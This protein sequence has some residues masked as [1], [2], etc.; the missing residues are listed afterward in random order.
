MGIGQR[1]QVQ[2][3]QI[4]SVRGN[5]HEWVETEGQKVGCWAEISNPRGYREYSDGQ[6]Q[7]GTTKVFLI[8]FNFNKY[9]NADWKIRY[10]G[11]DWTISARE[12]VDEK[13]FYWRFTAQSKADV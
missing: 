8:R 6:T 3:I 9:P 1:R 12:S 7:L 5:Q 11:K 13:R 2:L 4:L 10:E